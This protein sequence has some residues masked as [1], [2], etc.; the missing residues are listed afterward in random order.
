MNLKKNEFVDDKEQFMA[1]INFCLNTRQRKKEDDFKK[2]M[3]HFSDYYPQILKS[4]KEKRYNELQ[5]IVYSANGVGQK[6]GSLILEIIYLYSKYRNENIIKKLYV[7][8]DI[9]TERIFSDSL[10][11]KTPKSYQ[12][13]TNNLKFIQFQDSLNAYTNDRGRIYFDY[14]WFIGKMFCAKITDEKSRGY[15]LCNYCWIKEHCKNEKWL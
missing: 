5:N 2:G 14:L 4:I 8:I 9:H 12:L 15:K 11:I 7:P 1:F 10:G 6:I 3:K 13:K